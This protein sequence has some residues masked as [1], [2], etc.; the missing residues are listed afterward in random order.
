MPAKIT[1]QNI[2]VTTLWRNFFDI[3]LLMLQD[4]FVYVEEN[5]LS[6]ELT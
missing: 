4:H 2:M 6:T 3:F 5:D 1:K